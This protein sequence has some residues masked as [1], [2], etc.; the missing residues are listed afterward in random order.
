[1]RKILKRK[2]QDKIDESLRKI[3]VNAIRMQA[4]VSWG[5][6]QYIDT[7]RTIN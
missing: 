3:L 5:K 4:F 2:K 7:T 6:V 1:M